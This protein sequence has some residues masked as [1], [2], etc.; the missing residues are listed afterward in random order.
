MT[1]DPSKCRA[2]AEWARATGR[3]EGAGD[4]LEIADQLEAAA[5]LA[6]LQSLPSELLDEV[7]ALRGVVEVAALNHIQTVRERDAAL[8]EVEQLRQSCPCLHVAPCHARCS[9]V[10]PLSSSGCQRCCSY[11]SPEQQ[12]AAA[13]RLAREAPATDE[14]MIAV[15]DAFT[16][17]ASLSG[18]SFPQRVIEDISV[19]VADQ[20]AG[21]VRS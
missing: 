5:E 10:A 13:E 4:L 18:E 19:R 2:L 8:S 3:N 9:C 17:V 11:G 21:K 15:R 14:A 16:Q 20:L 6:E 1:P 12:R 7:G